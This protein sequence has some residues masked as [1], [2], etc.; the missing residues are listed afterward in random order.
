MALFLV[1]L[2]RSG[3]D[4]EPLRG[5]ADRL[6]A[7]AHELTGEG[8]TVRYLDTIFLPTDETCL[9]VLDA[10]SEA[11]VRTVARRAG[12]DIDRVVLAEQVERRDTSSSTTTRKEGSP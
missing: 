12:I 6:A 9:H 3:S 10:A 7:C 5:T 2:Y 1:E 11:D 4:G 8:T